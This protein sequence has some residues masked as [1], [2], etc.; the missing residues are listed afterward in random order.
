[1]GFDED[2][3]TGKIILQAFAP[4]VKN[5]VEEGL[6]K[7]TIKGHMENLCSLGSEIIRG[8][9]FDEDQRKL[10]PKDLLLGYVSEVGG[11]WVHQWNPSD[12]TEENK[13]RSYNAT[14]R[15]LYNFMMP[16]N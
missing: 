3:V 11:P 13:I 8:V 2:L 10:S 12:K 14:C 16:T 7:K 4:F 9:H 5:L 1:M 6:S 15:K